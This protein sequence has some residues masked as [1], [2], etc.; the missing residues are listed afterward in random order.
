[1]VVFAF[2]GTTLKMT[3]AAQLV[4][5]EDSAIG[6]AEKPLSVAM[7]PVGKLMTEPISL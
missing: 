3:G 1:M 6:D 5:A 2:P 4:P 7:I